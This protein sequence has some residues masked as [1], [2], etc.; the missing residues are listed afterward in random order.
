M[1]LSRFTSLLLVGA[2]L[3]PGV[4]ARAQPESDAVQQL[5]EQVKA[6]VEA[7]QRLRD[8]EAATEKQLA[9]VQAQLRAKIELGAPPPT[10]SRA[11]RI[12]GDAGV[13]FD[14]IN[15]QSRGTG[16]I[17]E[18]DN[19]TFRQRIRLNFRTSISHH[20]EAGLQISTGENPNPASPFV[21]M[22]DAFRGKPFSLSQ[23]F[24]T[25]H[26]GNPADPRELVVH[27]GKMPNPFWRAEVGPGGFYDSEIVW[28]HDVYPEGIA[29]RVPMTRKGS[30]I[31]LTN[32]MGLFL[33]NWVTPQRFIGLLSPIYQFENQ[34]KLD[35]GPFH[36]AVGYL[37]FN[38]L[39][40]GLHVPIF[41][42][43]FGVDTAPATSAFLLRP[44]LQVTNGQYGYGAGA[45]GFGSDQFH[46]I[47]ITTQYLHHNGQGKGLHPFLVGEFLHNYSVPVANEGWGASAGVVR[48]GAA[49]GGWAGWVTY[50]DVDADATLATFADSDLGIGTDYRGFQ[51]GGAYRLQDNLAFRGLF[52]EFKGAPRKET[53][54]QRIF[55]DLV[56]SF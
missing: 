21:I 50:R 43:G 25:Y 9:D 48:G 12:F 54:L 38:N 34:L 14:V 7:Q 6:L 2:L 51:I 10:A 35:F 33:I 26:F 17:P 19:G 39:N 32:N 37:F 20:T 11:P 49:Q 16:L 53:S 27:F 3:S 31:A 22:G 56:R 28:D 44:P 55:L 29:L 46:I 18:G 45:F 52:M 13:R 30:R 15:P 36:G 41:I 8:Q 24:F 42:P 4:V 47:N 5:Q 40:Q 23:G 1:K